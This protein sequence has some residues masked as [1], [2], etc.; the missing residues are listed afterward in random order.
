MLFKA[1]V[2]PQFLAHGLNNTSFRQL[3]GSQSSVYRKVSRFRM[4]NDD[5]G[6]RLFWI[7]LKF[8]R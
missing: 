6:G 1:L 3:S 4:M 8:F 5:R 2:P 7:E